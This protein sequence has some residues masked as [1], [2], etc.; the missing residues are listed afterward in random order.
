M[1]GS[2]ITRPTEAV[3]VPFSANQ[4]NDP[5]GQAFV[6]SLEQAVYPNHTPPRPRSPLE[7]A[8]RRKPSLDERSFSSPYTPQSGTPPRSPPASSHRQPVLRR[9]LP[10]EHQWSVFGQLMENELRGSETRRA[11]RHPSQMTPTSESQS[12]YFTSSSIAEDRASR[13]QSP[14]ADLPPSRNDIP[15]DDYDSDI[16]ETSMR[17]SFAEPVPR[18][19]SIRRL[20]KLSNLHRNIVKCAIAYF[21]ASLFTFSPYLSSFVSDI[22]SDNEPGDTGPSPAG[23]MVATVYVMAVYPTF[24]T[25]NDLYSAVYFN[26]AKTIGGMVEADLYCFMGLLYATFISLNS[27]AMFWW[28]DVK[29]GLEWLAD[30]FAILWIGVGMAALSW[31]KA[32]VNKP[33]FGTGM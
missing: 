4:D 30:L 14:V 7:S 8:T 23:H 6:G 16:S 25:H 2:R 27:M 15:E 9:P 1:N 31:T 5:V 26:P 20:P 19:Y 10:G 11:K 13:V 28:I 18:W 24:Y 21:I 32:W 3:G 33:S 12:G 22:T 17:Q 29:P